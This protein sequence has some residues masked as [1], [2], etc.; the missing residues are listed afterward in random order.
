MLSVVLVEVLVVVDVLGVLDEQ[1]VSDSNEVKETVDSAIA[2][3]IL[4]LRRKL[5]SRRAAAIGVFSRFALFNSF[6][7]GPRACNWLL[8]SI[9]QRVAFRCFD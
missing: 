3:P 4:L 1:Q 9:G 2:T 6:I 7:F 5:F 8:L